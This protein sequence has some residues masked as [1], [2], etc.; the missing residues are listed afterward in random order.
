MHI[1]NQCASQ[2]Q[3]CTQ[4]ELLAKPNP[5]KW[6]RQEIL[7][8]LVDSAHNNLRRFITGQYENNPH[9]VYDPDF[10]VNANQY[11]KMDKQEVMLLWILLNQNICNVLVN[12]P[13]STYGRT[14]NTGKEQPNLHTLE[15][16][17]IDYVKHL[18]YHMNQVLPGSFEPITYP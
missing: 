10:W 9:I 16:L 8:H 18:Q 2:L 14:C 6:S 7:G 1:V 13:E 4:E 5:E 12:M 3:A 11:Q 17:A 15:W